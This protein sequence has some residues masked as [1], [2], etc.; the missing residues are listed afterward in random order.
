[1]M[2]MLAPT[3]ATTMSGCG[4]GSTVGGEA[5]FGCLECGTTCCR[6]CAI[7]LESATYCRAC[8]GSL[9]ETGSVQAADPFELH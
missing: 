7:H 1:M 9:L 5:V 2:S 8:A 4:C 3:E 6:T